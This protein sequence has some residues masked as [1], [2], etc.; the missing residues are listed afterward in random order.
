MNYIKLLFARIV[1][2]FVLFC[3]SVQLF[4][5]SLELSTD[6]ATITKISS[7]A[8]HFINQ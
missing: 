8:Y 5:I 4:F 3:L 6:D 1:L 2:I 7:K